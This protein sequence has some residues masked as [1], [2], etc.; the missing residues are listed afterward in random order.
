M[1]FSFFVFLLD[2]IGQGDNFEKRV[3]KTDFEIVR[4]NSMKNYGVVLD[5]F[6][7]EGTLD[8]LMKDFVCHI[9]KGTIDEQLTLTKKTWT[10]FT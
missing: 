8:T 9:S 5:D 6:G 3:H 2:L 10:P 7:M 1:K 4:P